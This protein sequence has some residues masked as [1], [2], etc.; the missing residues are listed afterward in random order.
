M[1]ERIIQYYRLNAVNPVAETPLVDRIDK[2]MI[3][4][5]FTDREVTLMYKRDG[6]VYTVRE[7][8]IGGRPQPR[9]SKITVMC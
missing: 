6:D 5:I 1:D 2:K 4:S 7:D 8:V 3:T 9:G